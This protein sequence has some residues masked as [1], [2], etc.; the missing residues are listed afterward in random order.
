MSLGIHFSILLCQ[1]V[2]RLVNRFRNTGSVQDRNRSGRPCE[3]DYNLDDSR[4]TLLRSP[5]KSQRKLSLQSG[6]SFGSIQIEHVS[7]VGCVTFRSPCILYSA[8]LLNYTTG[9]TQSA[10]LCDFA[11][12]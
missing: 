5:R 1:T 2:S 11:L 4:Q 7:G 8:H 3:S 6:L 10:V 9:V 12:N